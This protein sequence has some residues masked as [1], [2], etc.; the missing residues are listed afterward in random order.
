MPTTELLVALMTWIAAETGLP[1]PA[2][3]P[4]IR[5]E[6]PRVMTRMGAEAFPE[7]N[8]LPV[9]GV[10]DRRSRRL[11]LPTGWSED[12]LRDQAILVHELTHHLQ[13]EAGRRYRCREESEVDAYTV[14]RRW[15]ENAGGDFFALFNLNPLTLHL[16]TTCPVGR[17]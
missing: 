10:Y 2:T 11:L 9:L 16:L 3:P 1:T 12:S 4:E 15:V 7:A 8:F 17:N 13:A 6:D 5:L 14:Q